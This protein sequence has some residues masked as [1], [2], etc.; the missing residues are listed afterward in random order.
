MTLGFWS[1][2][3]RRSG[4]TAEAR[5]LAEEAASLLDCGAPSLLNEAPVY[6]ALHDACVDAGD[7]Q[8]A[9]GAIERGMPH[10]LR[11][12]AGLEDTPYAHAYLTGLPHNAGL[13]E[14]A[15]AYGL[16]PEAIERVLARH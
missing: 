1:E 7:L 14:A 9:R 5:T 4:N 3:E 2:A 16:V 6:L 10:L 15:E 12:L 13:L 8:G 11:R